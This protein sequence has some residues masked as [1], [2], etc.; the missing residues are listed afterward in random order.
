[1]H[2]FPVR[3][4]DLIQADTV[5]RMHELEGSEFLDSEAREP[6]AHERDLCQ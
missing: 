6:P 5:S 4:V 1:M 2:A 3:G